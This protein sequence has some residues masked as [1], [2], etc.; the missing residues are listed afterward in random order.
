MSTEKLLMETG[1]KSA[2]S[3]DECLRTSV[4][5]VASTDAEYPYQ[6]RV[7]AVRWSVRVN[8][9][10]AEPLYTLFVDGALVG[11]LEDWPE[12]WSRPSS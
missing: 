12:S 6:S 4:E 1:A 5:W 9:F 11:D 10:P 7:G 3:L 8:D 2:F